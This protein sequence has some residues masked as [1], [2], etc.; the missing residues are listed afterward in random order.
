MITHREIYLA[1]T[2]CFSHHLVVGSILHKANEHSQVWGTGLHSPD[3]IP[4]STANAE[5]FALRGKLTEEA[6]TNQ[7]DVQLNNI[8]FGDPALLMPTYYSPAS[9]PKIY[10]VG[11]VPHY[12][13]QHR[14][15]QGDDLPSGVCVLNVGDDLESFISQLNLCEFI[16]SSSLHGLILADAYAIPNKWIYLSDDIAGGSFKFRDY[17]STTSHT[18]ENHKTLSSLEEWKSL[19][20]DI[21]NVCSVKHYAFDLKFLQSTLERLAD[22][23]H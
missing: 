8:A 1:R 16:L 17:Y 21:H 15:P 23:T 12:V 2:R 13:D 11:I 7:F 3:N 20:S 5:I 18:A 22:S 19:F 6:L 14:V 9:K 4:Q 10:T